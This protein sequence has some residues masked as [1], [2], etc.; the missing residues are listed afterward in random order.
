MA[1]GIIYSQSVWQMAGKHFVGGRRGFGRDLWGS[2][3]GLLCG[4]LG[5]GPLFLPQGRDTSRLHC[6][7][8]SRWS[9]PLAEPVLFYFLG[10]ADWERKLIS[11]AGAV[12]PLC[13]T[14]AIT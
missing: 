2:V 8:R 10:T 11:R 13:V 14:I 3:P 9:L 7:C 6:G 4:S 1:I 12:A 5:S